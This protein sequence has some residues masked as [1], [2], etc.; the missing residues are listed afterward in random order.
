MAIINLCIG[1]MKTG[2]T[3]LQSFLR[4]NSEVLEKQGFCYPLMD[5]EA[6]SYAKSRNGHFLIFGTVHPN[7]PK[8]ESQITEI[9][10]FCYRK[11]EELAKVYPNIILSDEL[12]WHHSKKQEN[13]WQDLMDRLEKINCQLRV[14]V[15]L[16]RQDQLVQSL[17]KQGVKSGLQTSCTF[18]KYIQK[19]RYRYFPLDYYAHLKE[20]E[21]F[22]GKDNLLVRVYESGQYEGEDRTLISD[23]MHTL[24]I[25]LTEQFTQETERRN[26]SLN[27]NFI[28]I[29]R[30]LNSLP[31]YR[32]MDNF[33]IKPL[34][35]AS[36]FQENHVK[37]TK[38]SLF[39][40]EEQ[41]AFLKE[42]EESNRKVAIEFLNRK[43]GILFR[44]PVQ[45]LPAYQ[46][47][48]NAMCRDLLV[49]MAEALFDQQ[50]KIEA[51]ENQIKTQRHTLKTITSSLAYRGYQKLKNTF[52]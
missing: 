44:E 35:T 52:H 5:V 4:N 7:I 21:K 15:Y 43:D 40:Y 51:L 10:Q 48:P 14:I 12:I 49:F 17:W 22:V 50:K 29:K 39:S 20:I 6:M 32:E 2:T 24:N 19:K 41:T 31:E 23:F 47:S 16:R 34:L 8:T 25:P 26:P 1:T 27:G 33:M 38:T 9:Q 18:D 46:I 11:L 28:E 13:F 36:L 45:N 3:A 37:E 42:Y 30:I